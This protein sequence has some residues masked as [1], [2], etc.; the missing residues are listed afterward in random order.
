[1][2]LGV[3]ILPASLVGSKQRSHNRY[4][5]GA[6]RTNNRNACFGGSCFDSGKDNLKMLDKLADKYISTQ[7]MYHEAANTMLHLIKEARLKTNIWMDAKDE[8]K[9]ATEKVQPA[10][11][12][13]T[14]G[15]APTGGAVPQPAD[16]TS[17]G[18]LKAKVVNAKKEMD[19]ALKKVKQA[20]KANESGSG[21][22]ES[23]TKYGSGFAAGALATLAFDNLLQWFSYGRK[24]PDEKGSNN[25]D[26]EIGPPPKK[27]LPNE[28]LLT[29]GTIIGIALG[30]LLLLIGIWV[31]CCYLSSGRDASDE[32]STDLRPRIMLQ[33]SAPPFEGHPH[34]K[35]P[36]SKKGKPGSSKRK[37]H[38][39]AQS[40]SQQSSFP[41]SEAASSWASSQPSV[42][43]QSGR[44]PSGRRA[45]STPSKQM[46]V[47]SSQQIP[48]FKPAPNST[49]T[50]GSSLSL[51]SHAGSRKAPSA[52]PLTSASE[53][54]NSNVRPTL[55]KN[56]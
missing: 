6:K 37:S 32:A 31:T 15:S 24:P 28:P 23:L 19:D 55:S 46:M 34:P 54:S 30:V 9:R 36:S 10:A 43:G 49:F 48:P 44:P 47:P 3:T 14:G 21:W 35:P 18:D 56:F 38:K 17:R 22:N 39:L 45:I 7:T 12:N 1:M 52:R 50:A 4:D 40:P 5:K 8:L 2:L 53:Q 11:G 13:L 42:Q 26:P 29:T 20:E 33:P 27:Q 25:T 16:L 41:S 51:S